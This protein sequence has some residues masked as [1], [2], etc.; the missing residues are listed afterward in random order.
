[1]VGK[2][3]SLFSIFFLFFLIQGREKI[4]AICGRKQKKPVWLAQGAYHTAVKET[5]TTYLI[6]IR[7]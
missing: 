2:K 4:S 5:L 7:L 6:F 3:T 1:M